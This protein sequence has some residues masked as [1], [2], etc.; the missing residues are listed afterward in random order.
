[1]FSSST[2]V[3]TRLKYPKLKKK[4]MGERKKKEKL[5]DVRKT[6]SGKRRR[7]KEEDIADNAEQKD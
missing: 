1:M 7:M 3:C 5:R 6:A 4:K 2:A